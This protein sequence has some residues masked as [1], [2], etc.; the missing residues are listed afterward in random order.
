MGELSLGNKK[1][2]AIVQALLHNPKLL[3]LDEPTNGLDPLI[4]TRL[5][6]LILEERKK[7]TTIFFSSHNLVEVENL[8]DRVAIIKEGKIVDILEMKE[9]SKEIGIKVELKSK[10]ITKE[11]IEGLNGEIISSKE[12]EKFIFN[13]FGEVDKLIK[14]LA[15][16]KIDEISI[17]EQSLEE[18]FMNYYKKEGEN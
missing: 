18:K 7:G 17:G 13:Y 5:F 3:I 8:C 10:E 14:A 15:L 16:I 4:Q 1:K 2:V 6:E 11:F 12:N 9:V